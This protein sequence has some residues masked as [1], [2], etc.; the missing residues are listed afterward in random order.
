MRDMTK[1]KGQGI[2]I[3]TLLVTLLLTAVMVFAAACQE[4]E[5]P[6]QGAS[7]YV[8]AFMD[9]ICKGEFDNYMKYSGETKEQAQKEYDA[10][11]DAMMSTLGESGA[12]EDVQKRFV[13]I[14]KKLLA[15]SKYTVGEAEE[16]EDGTFKVDVSI[17]PITGIYDG[18][19]QELQDEATAYVQ[20]K[21]KNGESIDTAE[22]TEYVFNLML[23]KI[24]GRMDSSGYGEP[25]TVTVT[26][27]KNGDNYEL[28]D[29]GETGTE[30]GEALIDI[31]EIQQ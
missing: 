11:T 30:I 18:L 25:K 23:D 1:N 10:M 26:V 7:G 21:T 28:V 24:E 17:E 12:S 15:K 27:K 2:M 9:M 19:S 16:Q 20:E 5:S 22:A 8:E 3:R 14:Y 6:A 29:S 31:S 13:E 4:K